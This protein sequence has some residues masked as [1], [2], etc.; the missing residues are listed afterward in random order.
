[1]IYYSL[2]VGAIAFLI[3]IIFEAPTKLLFSKFPALP[4]WAIFSILVT[5]IPFLFYRIYQDIFNKEKDVEKYNLVQRNK[6]TFALGVIAGS[7]W[8]GYNNKNALDNELYIDNGT[9]SNVVI[10][11]IDRTNERLR[12]EIGPEDSAI[13]EIPIGRNIITVNGEEKEVIVGSRE[14]KY[15]YNINAQN[16]YILTD[17]IYGDAND[18]EKSNGF[19]GV[20]NDEFFNVEADLI[21]EAPESIYGSKNSTYRKTVL[22]RDGKNEKLE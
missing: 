19:K 7:I 22:L 15:I 21:F 17:I 4:T 10:E 20:F 5:S 1:M 18:S 13:I 16:T 14:R 2:K 8:L 9:L 3:K 6:F 12:R 11:Y